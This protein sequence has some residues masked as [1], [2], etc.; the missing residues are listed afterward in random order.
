VL[1]VCY[2]YGRLITLDVFKSNSDYARRV[3]D[4]ILTLYNKNV[5]YATEGFLLLGRCVEILGR[6]AIEQKSLS[7]HSS[8]N[9]SF[10]TSFLSSHEIRSILNETSMFISGKKWPTLLDYMYKNVSPCPEMTTELKELLLLRP[11]E[12]LYVVG[13]L[14]LDIS[15]PRVLEV[16]YEG[17]V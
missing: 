15:N 13:A 14:S 4:F 2:F 9:M 8:K 12:L 10:D 11:I 16:L 6:L 1:L 5:L 3:L 17:A 7:P